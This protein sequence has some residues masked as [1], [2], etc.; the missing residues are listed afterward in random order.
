M[1]NNIINEQVQE[2]NIKF[3]GEILD[4]K[5]SYLIKTIKEEKFS[6]IQII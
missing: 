5:K 4:G 3:Y 6:N 1:G 2:Y